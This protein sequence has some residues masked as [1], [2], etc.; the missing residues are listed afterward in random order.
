MKRLTE[1]DKD[2]D[3][4]KDKIKIKIYKGALACLNI[5]QLHYLLPPTMMEYDNT[6]RGQIDICNSPRPYTTAQTLRQK[7]YFENLHNDHFRM[8]QREITHRGA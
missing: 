3:K 6:R 2:K 7:Q 8:Q 4:D 5:Y 1:K